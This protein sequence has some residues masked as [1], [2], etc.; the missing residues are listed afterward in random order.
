M[1]HAFHLLHAVFVTL[2]VLIH[3]FASDFLLNEAVF[4]GVSLCPLVQHM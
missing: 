1:F 2:L 3:F 4:S